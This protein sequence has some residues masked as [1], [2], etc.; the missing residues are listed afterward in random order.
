MRTRLEIFTEI[1]DVDS[2]V[3][4]L[5]EKIATAKARAYRD[6]TYVRSDLF[7]Q[8]QRDLSDQKRKRQFLQLEMGE[9]SRAERREAQLESDKIFAE[10]LAAS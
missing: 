9:I 1:Q 7:A 6:R 4:D 2:R 3:A 5:K 10:K 8:W